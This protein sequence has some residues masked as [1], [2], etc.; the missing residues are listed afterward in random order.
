M[1]APSRT[2]QAQLDLDWIEFQI[3][4][5]AAQRISV[6]AEFSRGLALVAF[7]VAQHFLN[8]ATAKLA[9][10]LLIGDAAGVH[11]YDKIIQFAFHTDL[12]NPSS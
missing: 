11:L 9:D 7:V 1:F 10:S 5:N 2:F 3:R 12:S 8:V 6:Y 4:H